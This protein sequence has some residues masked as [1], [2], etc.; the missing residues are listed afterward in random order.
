MKFR[1]TVFNLGDPQGNHENCPHVS[2]K[3]KP[4]KKPAGHGRH[5]LTEGTRKI[6][7]F[8]YHWLRLAYLCACGFASSRRDDFKK[9]HDKMGRLWMFHGLR[10]AQ[11][12]DYE[13]DVD[14][15]QD[16]AAMIMEMVA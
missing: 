1:G 9:W 10:Q 13:L 5:I 12:T 2:R 15:L 14:Q 6:C 7:G 3:G 16:Q 4:C 11:L 8:D